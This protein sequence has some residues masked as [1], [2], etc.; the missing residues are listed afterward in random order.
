MHKYNVHQ[1]F[2]R[3]F[4]EK[5]GTFQSR[6]CDKVQREPIYEIKMHLYSYQSAAMY[7]YRMNIQGN[8]KELWDFIFKYILT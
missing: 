3:N 5:Y 2:R 7:M 1:Y 6:L 4:K 8:Q